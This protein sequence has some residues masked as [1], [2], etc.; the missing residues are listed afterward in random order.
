MATQKK[1]DLVKEISDKLAKAKAL[2]FADYTGLTHKQLEDLRKLIKK[3]E[4][5]LTVTKNTLFKRALT[6]TK[7]TPDEKQ[8]QGATATLFAYADEAAPLKVLVK[9]FK[10][11]AKGVIKGGLLGNQTLT[12]GEV[13][14]LAKLPSRE[15][16]LSQLAAELQYPVYGLHRSLSWNLNKL[17]WV[18]DAVK[19]KKT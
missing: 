13:E 2:V 12:T 4:A 16:L 15:I 9:F 11:A 6:Q 5:E 7:K 19:N 17:V 18:L 3:T 14:R 1:I 8:L 10:D